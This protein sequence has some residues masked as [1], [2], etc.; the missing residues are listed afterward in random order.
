M[1][2]YVVQLFWH[3]LCI[4]GDTVHTKSEDVWLSVNV[5][6]PPDLIS[7]VFDFKSDKQIG[8][9]LFLDFL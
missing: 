4:W 7:A 9:K 5:K 8:K 6:V 1:L 3:Y 2:S